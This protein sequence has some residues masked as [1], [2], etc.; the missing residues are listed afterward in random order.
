MRSSATVTLRELS[1]TFI[2]PLFFERTSLSLS[3]PNCTLP[4]AFPSRYLFFFLYQLYSTVCFFVFLSFFFFRRIYNYAP[5][6]PLYFFLR[7]C[8]IVSLRRVRDIAVFYLQFHSPCLFH[9]YV[10]YSTIFCLFNSFFFFLCFV[11]F[12]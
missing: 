2:Q 7:I 8:I 3:C 4:K 5:H 12:F 6:T 9:N 11:G 1:H 10:L